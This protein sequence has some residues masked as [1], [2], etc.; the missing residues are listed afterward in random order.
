M[1]DL[2]DGGFKTIMLQMLKELK[3]GVDKNQEN[4]MWT[5]WKY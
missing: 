1:I 2:L 3:E 5:K 4:N